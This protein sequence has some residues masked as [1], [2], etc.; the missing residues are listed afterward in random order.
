MPILCDPTEVRYLSAE[1]KAQ[2]RSVTGLEERTGADFLVS[3]LELPIVSTET[4]MQHCREGILIQRKT[5]PDLITS[6]RDGRLMR[7]LHRMLDSGPLHWLAITGQVSI[8]SKTGNA[9]MA[10]SIATIAYMAY[11]G[12][13][14]WYQ[15]R[16]GHVA[17]H[18]QE[19]ALIPWMMSWKKKLKTLKEQPVKT[20]LPR[21]PRQLLVG[22]D[23][24]GILAAIFPEIG[25]VKAKAVVD[26]AKGE[27]QGNN[28]PTLL[29]AIAILT[30]WEYPIKGVTP[31]IRKRIRDTFGLPGGPLEPHYRIAVEYIEPTVQ[32]AEEET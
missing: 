28:S 6:I 7:S 21:K 25:P 12:A 3:T 29:N 15:L 26:I 8:D 30:D 16:G 32:I 24:A 20:L 13:L 2:C 31:R 4:L 11:A 27:Q 5:M 1:G 22:P 23:L 17:Y 19:G 9:V 18:P 14:D 10:D